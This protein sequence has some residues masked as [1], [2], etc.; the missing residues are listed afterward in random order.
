MMSK[1]PMKAL[2]QIKRYCE[3]TQCRRCKFG[4]SDNMTGYVGCALMGVTPCDWYVEGEDG[5]QDAVN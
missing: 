4:V 2:E 5:E 3:K 1:P